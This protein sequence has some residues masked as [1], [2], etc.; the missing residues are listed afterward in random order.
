MKFPIL[1][2][3]PVI[4]GHTGRADEPAGKS[5]AGA[6]VKSVN[7]LFHQ[8]W[9]TESV[10]PT[11]GAT[12]AE[13][14]RRLYLDLAGR[15]PAVSEVRR[16]AADTAMDKRQQVVYELLDSPA[17]VRH[18]TTT[19]RNALLPQAATQPQFRGLIPGFEAWLWKHISSDSP[20]D[21]IVREIISANLN[22]GGS[23]LASTTSPDAFFVV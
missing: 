21:Q 5:S 23:A 17:S 8:S 3:L 18:M 13:Y 1:I 20:Y 14:L 16:F 4:L 11:V 9:K 7:G 6:V 12:D 15:V 10:T 22:V 2:L 19:W